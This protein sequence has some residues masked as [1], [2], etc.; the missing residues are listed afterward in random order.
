MQ[1][2]IQKNGCPDFRLGM[3]PSWE[4]N[5]LLQHT[6]KYLKILYFILYFLS[7]V[8]FTHFII[9]LCLSINVIFLYSYNNNNNNNV[10]YL[11]ER[12][13]SSIWLV[14]IS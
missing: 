12:S 10:I 4:A 5:P 3:K 6:N 9:V 14:D 8:F 2:D 7:N 11:N 1:K 13:I